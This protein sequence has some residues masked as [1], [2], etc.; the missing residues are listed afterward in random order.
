M[1]WGRSSSM[2]PRVISRPY[3]TSETGQTM[4]MVRFQLWCGTRAA[5][6]TGQRRLAAIPTLAPVFKL[7]TSL[8]ETILHSFNG[9]DGLIPRSGVLRD[10][11]G[12]F[13]GTTAFG[14]QTF[15][16]V[17]FK[18]DSAGSETILHNLN[19][20]TDG[21]NPWSTPIRDTAGN[22]YVTA[23]QGGQYGNGV[24]FKIA[25][26]GTETILQGLLGRKWRWRGTIC[27][28]GHGCGG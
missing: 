27:G 25:P 17:V 11:A 19:C 5:T 10:S 1:A 9:S 6:Y 7:D 8:N 28:C 12:N 22:L 26:D 15:C 16:G 4:A 23:A 2:I 21:F 14:G 3:I 20:G 13:Y 18:I 24:L